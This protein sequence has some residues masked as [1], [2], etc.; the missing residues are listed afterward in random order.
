M[1]RM[2]MFVAT[3][4]VLASVAYAMPDVMSEIQRGKCD[5]GPGA[6]GADE[7]Y[8]G[9]FVV[10]GDGVKGQEKR[11][12]FANT[13]WK[14]VK[15]RDGKAGEDCEVFWNVVGGKVPASGC[16]QCDFG[17]KFQADV[18][19]DKSTCPMDLMLKSRHWQGAYDLDVKDDGTMDV[20]FAGSGKALGTGYHDGNNYAYRT[21]HRC[22]WF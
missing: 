5:T 13:K 18:D 17:V 14:A 20:Y 1:K 4:A 10:D 22:V 7:H 6:A 15:G 16:V 11:L 3:G 21:A 8:V 9:R 2:T 12:L 19:F